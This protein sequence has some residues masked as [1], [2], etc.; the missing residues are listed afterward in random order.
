MMPKPDKPKELPVPTRTSAQV[1][2]AA[3]AQRQ[4]AFAEMSASNWLTGGLG[5]PDQKN[6]T[7]AVRLLGG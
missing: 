6:K 4:Q 1:Q 5:V 3:E 7:T 2:E